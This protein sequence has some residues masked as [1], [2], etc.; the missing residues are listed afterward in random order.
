ML[1]PRNPQFISRREVRGRIVEGADSNLDLVRAVY[2]PKHGRTA[3]GAKMTVVGRAPPASSRPSYRD[4]VR[5]PDGKE[6]AKRA[7]LFSTHL[8]VAKADSERLPS[9]LKPHLT[10]VAAARPLAHVALRLRLNEHLLIGTQNVRWRSFV[11]RGERWATGRCCSEAPRPSRVGGARVRTLALVEVSMAQAV[12]SKNGFVSRGARE[13]RHVL[14]Y[15]YII[16]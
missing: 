13:M 16:L 3:R 8:A 2:D 6:I 14:Q 7:G 9:D 5:W 4:F 1:A 11:R 10:A 12:S 15:K